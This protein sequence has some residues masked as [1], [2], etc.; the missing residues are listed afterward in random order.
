MSMSVTSMYRKMTKEDKELSKIHD[1]EGMKDEMDDM[2]QKFVDMVH[3]KRVDL[4][5]IGIIDATMATAHDAISEGVRL[6]EVE[7]QRKRA[8]DE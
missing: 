6:L 2:M 4:N 1:Y 7:K 8:N 5:E 3:F